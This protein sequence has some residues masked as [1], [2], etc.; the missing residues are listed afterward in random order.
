MSK[1]NTHMQSFYMQIT[2]FCNMAAAYTWDGKIAATTTGSH[3]W[4][5]AKKP[6]TM[7]AGCYSSWRG[8]LELWLSTKIKHKSSS[9]LPGFVLQWS[10]HLQHVSHDSH[11]GSTQITAWNRKCFRDPTTRAPLAH[12]EPLWGP[13]TSELWGPDPV[14]RAGRVWWSCHSH[15]GAVGRKASWGKPG[16]DP[17]VVSG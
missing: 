11:Q 13:K 4:N 12:L 14:Q 8:H 15:R 1:P 17:S 9:S 6:E 5:K 7:Q 2:I 16:M 3:G 10:F